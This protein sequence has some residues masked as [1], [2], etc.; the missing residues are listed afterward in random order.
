MRPQDREDRFAGD[1]QIVGRSGA[2]V[3]DPQRIDT[4][5][6]PFLI[7]HGSADNIVSPSQTLRLHT[8]LRVHGVE[9]TRYVRDGAEHGDMAAMLGRPE[10]A[11]PWSTEKF[12]GYITAFLAKHL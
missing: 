7:F 6:P 8:A 9:S 4:S 12:L 2:H 1:G 3:R 10:A 5:A 11:L